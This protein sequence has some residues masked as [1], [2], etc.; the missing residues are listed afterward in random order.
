MA[1][2]F[3]QLSLAREAA[4]ITS[5]MGIKP[6]T[7][8]EAPVD[9]ISEKIKQRAGGNIEKV[10]MFNPDAIGMWMFQ[11]YFDCYEAVYKHADICVPY[12][13]PMKSVTPVCF[14][15][16]YTGALP[17]V[18]GI[19]VYEK[20]VLSTDTIFDTLVRAGKRVA[21][22]AISGSSMA[23]IFLGREIDY[24]ILPP[25]TD[26]Y[27]MEAKATE[28][29]NENKHDFIVAYGQGYDDEEHKSGPE[30]PSSLSE[31][32]KQIAIFDRLSTR[33][34]EIWKNDR[35]LLV[36]A[37]DHGAH[38]CANGKGAHGEEIP[39]DLNILHFYGAYSP[40]K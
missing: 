34:K 37:P 2:F 13:S 1:E 18:H 21:I 30:S 40:S 17:D 38:L 31:F 22:V 19:K 33:A 6:P 23:S 14:A 3:N 8:A 4:T 9:F 15:T 39:E 29:L 26:D 24:Y 25:G 35:F 20:P 16:M 7:H 11:K 5:A 10:L 32:K 27:L 36:F 28:L 12:R